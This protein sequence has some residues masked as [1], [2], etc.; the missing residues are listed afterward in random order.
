LLQA[1]MPMIKNPI[2]NFFICMLLYLT[3]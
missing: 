3:A 2:S 1:I